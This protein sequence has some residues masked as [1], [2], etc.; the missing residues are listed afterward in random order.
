[1]FRIAP[2][3][4]ARVFEDIRR[5]AALED[6]GASLVAL[7][8]LRPTIDRVNAEVL[9]RRL[10]AT[11][12]V[13]A[14]ASG[15]GGGSADAAM[16]VAAQRGRRLLESATEDRPEGSMLPTFT[17]ASG[18]GAWKRRAQP[19]SRASAATSRTWSRDGDR[20][21]DGDDDGG[22]GDPALDE[23]AALDLSE[24]TAAA[25]EAAARFRAMLDFVE[26]FCCDD[27]SRRQNRRRPRSDDEPGGGG[28]DSVSDGVIGVL[29]SRHL[30]ALLEAL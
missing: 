14:A 30:D 3:P 2:D 28:D 16:A 6:H 22:V 27:P 17:G 1:M 13:G 29:D 9:R 10:D 4:G 8:L 21:A 26:P 25:E 11:A 24:A 5:A 18:G 23:A 12:G 20:D 7:A 19:L 15:A